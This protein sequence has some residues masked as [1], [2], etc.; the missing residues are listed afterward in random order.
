MRKIHTNVRFEP[1]VRSALK[2]RAGELSVRSP[3]PVT[4]SDVVRIA[5]NYYLQTAPS[6]GQVFG[7]DVW[8]RT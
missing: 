5:V 3:V 6:D 7:P 2:A 1:G 8:I 4:V